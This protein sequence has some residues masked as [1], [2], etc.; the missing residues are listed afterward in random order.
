MNRYAVLCQYIRHT[1]LKKTN[2]SQPTNYHNKKK[3]NEYLPNHAD[4]T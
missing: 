4:K 3:T 1:H 2:Q